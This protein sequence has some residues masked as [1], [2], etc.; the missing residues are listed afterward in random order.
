MLKLPLIP[1]WLGCINEGET[2]PDRIK[3]DLAD[4]LLENLAS[5]HLDIWVGH[6]YH[7]DGLLGQNDQHKHVDADGEDRTEPRVV[8]RPTSIIEGER[9]AEAVTVQQKFRKAWH[10]P[11]LILLISPI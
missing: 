11:N 2:N 5:I 4:F 3:T 10:F 1:V 6:V 9:L 7:L 8:G